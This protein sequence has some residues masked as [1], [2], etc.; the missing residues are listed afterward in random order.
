MR[1]QV[2]APE[3]RARH[4]PLLVSSW[5]VADL[6]TVWGAG[7]SLEERLLSGSVPDTVTPGDSAA[8]AA[9][10]VLAEPGEECDLLVAA[11]VSWPLS[12]G[13]LL[14]VLSL[15]SALSEGCIR[16]LSARPDLSVSLLAPLLQRLWTFAGV[17]HRTGWPMEEGPCALLHECGGP[18]GVA[19]VELLALW[20]GR[21]FEEYLGALELLAAAPPEAVE[22][23]LSLA[24]DRRL[25]QGVASWRIVGAGE[26]VDLVEQ[27]VLLS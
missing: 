21:V 18:L 25:E 10:C 6:S 5:T 24:A 11:A 27:A 23:L 17:N 20:G 26:L 9:L 3:N 19:A 12:R 13:D 7:S 22:I 2:P 16:A 1:S 4:E 8:V 15:P 14:S